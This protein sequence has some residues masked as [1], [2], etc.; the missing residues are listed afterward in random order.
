VRGA[1]QPQF[2][3][4]TN[5]T[6]FTDCRSPLFSLAASL[7]YQCLAIGILA[8]PPNSFASVRGVPTVT[9]KATRLLTQRCGELNQQASRNSI[10]GEGTSM[11]ELKSGYMVELDAWGNKSIISHWLMP[12]TMVLRKSSSLRKNTPAKR[13][14]KGPRIAPQ[15]P[16]RWS[17]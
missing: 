15:R 10:T 8:H 2:L 11:S 13:F 1:F 5:R 6:K 9:Q 3:P 12:T 16:K 17:A 7:L 4:P 14:A